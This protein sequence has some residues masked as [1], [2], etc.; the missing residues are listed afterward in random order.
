MSAPMT[1]TR[2]DVCV[3]A[4]ADLFRGDGEILCNPIGFTARLGGRLAR[5]TSE[6]EL[7]ML[8]FDALFVDADGEVEGWNPY[9]RMFDVVWR[10]NR[11][12]VMG[13]SQLDRYGNQ[14][15]AW[16]GS[17]PQ[18]PTRQLIGF[19]GAPGNT[20]NHVTSYFIGKHSTQV[21]VPHVDVVCGVGY[22]RI[23]R[24]SAESSRFHEIRRVVTNL[25]VLDFQTADGRMR[26]A[27]L[28]PGVTL[29]EVREATGFELEV[30]QHVPFTRLPTAQE[31]QVIHEFDPQ[32]QRFSEVADGNTPC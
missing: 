6:R 27:S 13:A 26:L 18:M 28:H 17:N 12:V 20:I 32:G 23:R 1:V 19:R 2:A 16:I 8:D 5:A 7:V 25:A 22:D 15:L 14:N 9:R 24:M 11:H 30:P 4:L 3:A 29:A 21:F 31:L 10:G